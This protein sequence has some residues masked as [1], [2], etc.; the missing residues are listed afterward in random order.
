MSID[1]K[2]GTAVMAMCHHFKQ[3][4]ACTH[5]PDNVIAGLRH[6]DANWSTKF[7]C[8]AKGIR[9]FSRQKIYKIGNQIR[10]GMGE[11][12]KIQC[13]GKFVLFSRALM[14]A[15]GIPD[16][17]KFDGISPKLF[18]KV[19]T[20]MKTGTFRVKSVMQL[21]MIYVFSRAYDMEELRCFI[22]AAVTQI[23]AKNKDLPHHKG[24]IEFAKEWCINTE[25][26]VYFNIM[27]RVL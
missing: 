21:R 5:V 10:D 12:V 11:M 23:I 16:S 2:F 15:H 3:N 25:R 18:I 26:K 7:M 27:L 22:E 14:R 1:T 8:Y 9:Y 13:L 20:W 17:A 4:C 24:I 19:C 6:I